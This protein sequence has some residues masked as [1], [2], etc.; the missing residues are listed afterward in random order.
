MKVDT[1]PFKKMIFFPEYNFKT[2]ALSGF[3]FLLCHFVIIF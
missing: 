1:S 3:L 2:P